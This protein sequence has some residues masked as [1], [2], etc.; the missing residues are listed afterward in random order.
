M[1][2]A[3]PLAKNISIDVVLKLANTLD[4]QY[5]AGIDCDGR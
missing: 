5:C 2:I 3:L 1:S 4:L